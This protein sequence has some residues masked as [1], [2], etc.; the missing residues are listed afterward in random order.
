VVAPGAGAVVVLPGPGGRVVAVGAVGEGVVGESVV[1]LVVEL[2][3][4]EFD[5]VG[6]TA[7]T[8]GVIGGSC[9]VVVGAGVVVV[10]VLVVVVVVVVEVVVVLVVVGGGEMTTV[11]DKVG[12]SSADGAWTTVR[13]REI[14]PLASSDHSPQSDTMQSHCASH[15]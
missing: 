3:D 2:V 8:A 15:G 6:G 14:I 9:F 11:S 7:V 10:V 1:V 13:S 12:Q 4:D 5:C